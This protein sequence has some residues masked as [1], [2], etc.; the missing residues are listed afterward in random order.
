MGARHSFIS[1]ILNNPSEY[2]IKNTISFY[3]RYDAPDIANN[4]AACGCFHIVE[5]FGYNSG[6]ITWKVHEY[7]AE[8]VEKFLDDESCDT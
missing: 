8:S 2:G 3:L 1:G 4:Y 6:P 5:Y 7:L